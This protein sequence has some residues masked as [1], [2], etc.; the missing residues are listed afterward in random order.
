MSR[1]IKEVVRSPGTEVID[2]CRPLCGCWELNQSS[3]CINYWFIS[4]IT[5]FIDFVSG[6]GRVPVQHANRNKRTM[7]RN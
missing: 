1:M 6:M 2:Y 4:L 3:Q 5:I 7:F